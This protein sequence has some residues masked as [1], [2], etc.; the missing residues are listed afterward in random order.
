MKRNSMLKYFRN[1]TSSFVVQIKELIITK[2]ESG[3]ITMSKKPEYQQKE[4]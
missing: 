2:G 3:K 4:R 1:C